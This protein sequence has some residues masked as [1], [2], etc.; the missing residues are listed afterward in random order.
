MTVCVAA[1]ASLIASSF[2]RQSLLNTAPRTECTYLR[3]VYSS[4]NVR[5]SSQNIRTYVPFIAVLI[6]IFLVTGVA[7]VLL[8]LQRARTSALVVRAP[9]NSQ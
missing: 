6:A 9:I 8:L 3:I 2:T 7:P 4:H 5:T 1:F